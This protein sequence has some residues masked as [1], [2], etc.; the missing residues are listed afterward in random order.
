MAELFVQII[1]EKV[2]VLGVSVVTLFRLRGEL[3]WINRER[4]QSL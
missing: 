1:E 4:D 2:A 3:S